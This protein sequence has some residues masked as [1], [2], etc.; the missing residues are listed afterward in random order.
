MRRTSSRVGKV[1][2]G[3]RG[4]TTKKS[5]WPHMRTSGRTN[6]VFTPSSLATLYGFCP[7]LE[8]ATELTT[9][10]LSDSKLHNRVP[11]SMFHCSLIKPVA[12][13][14]WSL[15]EAYFHV[16]MFYPRVKSRLLPTCLNLE[17]CRILKTKNMHKCNYSHDDSQQD[18]SWRY[19]L[20]AF[21]HNCSLPCLYYRF[22]PYFF[23]WSHSIQLRW[24][25]FLGDRRW[26]Q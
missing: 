11:W 16:R 20:N 4:T 6:H 10:L 24:P 12:S 13:Q 3:E 14:V 23:L 5:H 21:L 1:R 8:S 22:F 19:L 17:V 9:I 25:V 26:R 15:F 7:T 18:R 2:L